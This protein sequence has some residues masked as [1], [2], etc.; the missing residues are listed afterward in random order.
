MLHKE[1]VLPRNQKIG[2]YTGGVVNWRTWLVDR[3]AKVA[4]LCVKVEGMPLGTARNLDPDGV[5]CG[6]SGSH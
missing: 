2:F 3:A 4:G 1:T 5:C 6:D